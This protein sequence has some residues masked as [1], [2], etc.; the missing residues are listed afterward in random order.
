MASQ[1]SNIPKDTQYKLDKHVNLTEPILDPE[2]FDEREDLKIKKF[3][4][5]LEEIN[6]NEYSEESEKKFILDAKDHFIFRRI[7]DSIL[8][9]EFSMDFA[10]DLAKSNIRMDNV[11][12]KNLTYD[13]SK[14]L[15]AK[16]EK[17]NIDETYLIFGK[18]TG[19]N[20]LFD[21]A[22]A[23]IASMIYIPYIA[24]QALDAKKINEYEYYQFLEILKKMNLNKSIDL[25]P[26]NKSL[27]ENQTSNAFHRYEL[28]ENARMKAVEILKNAGETS[29]IEAL[30][31]D[32]EFSNPMMYNRPIEKSFEMK[33]LMTD[34]FRFLAKNVAGK[35]LKD[36][37]ANSV[38]NNLGIIQIG[39]EGIFPVVTIKNDEKLSHEAFIAKTSTLAEEISKV[40]TKK[41]QEK[42]IPSYLGENIVFEVMRY[43]EVY[44]PEIDGDNKFL[45]STDTNPKIQPMMSM[46]KE[47]EFSQISNADSKL[48]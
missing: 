31:L 43:G 42:K 8:S 47:Y 33:K 5:T 29:A 28:A 2:K 18:I 24:Q 20:K 34:Y 16:Y 30:G 46:M 40:F 27:N 11:G 4:E 41:I 37:I 39:G 12:F 44:I 22:H 6:M 32:K 38:I 7:C 9:K 35:S 45:S 23:L 25:Y 21:Y 48:G 1:S 10:M 14:N 17:S 3:Q 36:Y 26:T 19:M 15:L 13:M